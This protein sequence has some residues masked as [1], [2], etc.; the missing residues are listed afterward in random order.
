MVLKTAVALC[1]AALAP[2]APAFADCVTVH[3]HFYG[4][5]TVST[6]ETLLSGDTCFHRLRNN[7]KKANLFDHIEVAQYP[8]HGTLSISNASAFQ[9][10]SSAGYRGPDSYAIRICM[11]NSTGPSCS[12]VAFNAEI[13]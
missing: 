5:Q 2:S 4:H 8:S 3:F 1:L 12:T 13:H 10:R 9:Y 11:G 6:S 7:P